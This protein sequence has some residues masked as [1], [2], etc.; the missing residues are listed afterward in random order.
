MTII[1]AV[2]NSYLVNSYL[3]IASDNKAILVDPACSN[4]EECEQLQHIIKK[5]D[6][7]LT[8]II[9]T[10][11]HADH[12]MGAKLVMDIC[13]GIPFLMHQEAYPLYKRAN[14]YSLLMG[15]EKRELPDPTQYVTDEEMLQVSDMEIKILYT[16]GHAPGSICLYSKADNL[17][18]SGDV[19]FRNS[20]GRT[21][22]PGGNFDVLRNS[23]YEK[24]F[25]LPP[26]TDIFP[27][28]GDSTSIE[29]EK[30]N[31]PFL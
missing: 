22:L 9:A 10:H 15:F 26:N 19:L 5:H 4:Q 18:F 30:K 12:I 11:T 14:N 23:I 3:L 1:K 13:P 6:I 2:F 20:I 21:D 17:L 16:P 28:H 7:H 31:N 24:I 29:F 8:T 27:G 25:T